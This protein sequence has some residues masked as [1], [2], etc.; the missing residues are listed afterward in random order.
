MKNLDNLK[1]K[2]KSKKSILGL[3]IF[4]FL[5][6]LVFVSHGIYAQ[7][8]GFMWVIQGGGIGADSGHGIDVDGTDNSYVTG[9][10]N[11]AA[12]RGIFLAR[13]GPSGNLI[14]S[15]QVDG[16]GDDAGFS[17]AI[18]SSGSSVITGYFSDKVTNGTLTFATGEPNQTTLTSAGQADIFMAK[19]DVSGN[20]LWAKQAGGVGEDIGIDVFVDSSGNSLV[21]GYFNGTATFGKGESN[22][23]ILTSAGQPDIFLARY[24]ASGKL[25]WARRSGGTGEDWGR[26]VVV[27]ALGNIYLTGHFQGT[28][29]FDTTTLRS[30]GGRDIFLAK[31]DPSGNLLWIK[32]IGGSTDDIG[33]GI[34]VDTS[35]NLYLTGTFTGTVKFGTT[36]LT[37]AGNE[38]IFLA[39]YDTS[40]NLL[41]VRQA[42]GAGLDRPKNLFLDSLGNSTISGQF[43]ATATF[44]SDESGPVTL[45]SA[46]QDDIFIARYNTTGK[47]LWAKQ[48]GG[49]GTDVGFAVAVDS[50]GNSLVTGWFE[51]TATF[52]TT[53]LTTFG[54]TDIFIAKLAAQASSP[55]PTPTP[56]PSP[57]PTPTPTPTPIST[58]TPTPTATPT[59]TPT[60]NPNTYLP[61]EAES[62][63]LTSPMRTVANSLASGGYYIEVPNTTFGLNNNKG[64]AAFTFSIPVTGSYVIWGRVMGP[65]SASNSFYAQ[66]DSGTLYTW[67][68]PVGNSPVWVRVSNVGGPNPVSFNLSA[69]THTFTISGREDGTRLDKLVVTNDLN[70]TPR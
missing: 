64:A 11:G 60:P 18:D 28:A 21:T 70:Y 47:L 48:A 33:R 61:I 2:E 3:L 63:L 1:F 14:W 57:T 12:G 68:I 7:V 35:A 56:I 53:T 38:D 59:P 62:G 66:M 37:S 39:K 32:Q 41:W 55:T 51:N 67:D 23:T 40:G 46:G 34:D 45:T 10:F 13:Y 6:A 31:Y 24:D 5:L 49:T 36:T 26:E 65:D 20:F 27:D 19:Y 58:T 43:N 15:R 22:E 16:P 4:I 8:P 30:A 9:W 54:L 69:G 42:G 52:D 44:G 25:L 29:T 17:I 50:S